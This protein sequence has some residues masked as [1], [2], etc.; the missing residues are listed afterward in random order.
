MDPQHH[1]QRNRRTAS[2]AGR[3]VI[4]GLDQGQKRFPGNRDLHLVQEALTTRPL[5]G[6]DLLVV[7]K[8]QLEGVSHPFQSQSW[9]WI[10][11]SGFFRGS[12]EKIKAACKDDIVAPQYNDVLSIFD[13]LADLPDKSYIEIPFEDDLFSLFKLFDIFVHT[14]IDS[15]QETFGQVY[16]EAML[17]KVPSVITLSGSALDHA[18]HQENAWIV[19]YQN[20][21]QIAEG[22][23][24]LLS[25]HDLR[26]RMIRNAFF[27]RH[28]E[29]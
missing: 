29:L 19:T 25:D 17:S 1:V 20:S 5:F 24:A 14:P 4:H 9:I 12:L 16:V 15:I 23:L 11:F 2:F 21:D 28:R 6:E 27:M 13:C 7:R 3:L 8:A 26:E 10:D 18:R 22:I